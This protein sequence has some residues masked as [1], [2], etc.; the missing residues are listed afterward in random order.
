[1]FHFLLIL[2]ENTERT[3]RLARHAETVMARWYGACQATSLAGRDMRLLG[4][5]NV[6]PT[7]AGNEWRLGLGSWIGTTE[8][9]AAARIL[10]TPDQSPWNYD[11]TYCF[12]AGAL[13]EARACAVVD[14]LGRLHVYYAR[15]GN[16]TLLIS[17][18]AL[19]LG[20]L[21][22][23]EWAIDSVREF[24]AKGTVFDQR[25][26]FSGVDKFAPDT[27]Y[28][29]RPGQLQTHAIPRLAAA[30]P[31]DTPSILSAFSDAVTNNLSGILGRCQQPLLDLTGGFDSRLVLACLLQLRPARE[32]TTVVVG[33]TNDRDVLVANAIA[34]KLGLRHHHVTAPVKAD[35]T[36]QDLLKALLLT[37]AEYDILE[38]A[39]VMRIHQRLSQEFDASING[40][41]GEMIR[42]EWWQVFA[43]PLAPSRPWNAQRL[44]AR[45]FASDDWGESLLAGPPPESLTE[46]FA[47]LIEA[48][49]AHL[50]PETRA[51][52]LVDEVYLYMRMQRWQGRLASATHGIWPNYSPLLMQRPIAIAL[53]SPIALRRNGLMPRLLL[54]K[55]HRPLA[56]IPMVDGAPATRMTWRNLPRHLPRYRS[57]IAYYAKAVRN[58]LRHDAAAAP[59]TAMPPPASAAANPV[60]ISA[61]MLTAALYAPAAFDDTVRLFRQGLL[62]SPRTGRLLTLEH[63]AHALRERHA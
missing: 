29:F 39:K 15:P 49:V 32:I 38:Y 59:A 36:D 17:N 11:G 28:E 26:L 7:L 1:M 19:L 18:S 22:R 45:R 53:H 6:Q 14:P 43:R 10:A 4:W 63:A 60:A 2:D 46:H 12:L 31:S 13:D 58:R 44:A 34:R 27:L 33:A 3:E 40:S 23:A 50:G 8:P 30:I 20:A 62:S 24:L 16:S 42:D 48:T 41:G 21:T 5:G 57:R 61:D 9:P 47:G 52:R 51:T 54:E 25:S 55:L 56:D 37:D 35:Y